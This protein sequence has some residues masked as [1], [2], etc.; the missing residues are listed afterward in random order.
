MST[1]GLGIEKA[2][3]TELVKLRPE[4]DTRLKEADKRKREVMKARQEVMALL[5]R[6]SE[7]VCL[8]THVR[9]RLMMQTTTVSDMFLQLHHQLEALEDQVQR[10]ERAKRKEL[11]ERY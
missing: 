1:E 9:Q 11:K 2:D 7:F 6:Y 10:A 8:P 3:R 4:V 5:K